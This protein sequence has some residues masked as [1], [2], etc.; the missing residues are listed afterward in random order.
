MNDPTYP[1]EAYDELRAALRDG[2]ERLIAE[3]SRRRR[4]S[5]T[6]GRRVRGA[7]VLSGLALAATTFV[8]SPAPDLGPERYRRSR[9][10]H[11]AGAAAESRCPQRAQRGEHGRIDAVARRPRRRRTLPRAH[12]DLLPERARCGVRHR[13]CARRDADHG[14]AAE[15]RSRRPRRSRRHRRLRPAGGRRLALAQAQRRPNAS[16]FRSARSTSMSSISRARMRPTSALTASRWSPRTGREPRS[17]GPRC[18]PTGTRARQ[19][20]RGRPRSTSPRARTAA[21]SRRCSGSTASSAIRSPHPSQLV[22][23]DGHAVDIALEP[24]GSFHYDVPRARQGDFMTPRQLVGRDGEGR[25]V[26]ERPVAAVAYWR[27]ASR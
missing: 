1:V 24:D 20:C 7:P 16:R 3:R 4:T 26:V 11:A 9:R 2:V 17:P 21:T 27:A 14:H 12:H 5:R 8:G 23:D 6:L 18:P 13:H 19:T 25:V 15:R 10:G 22:Y